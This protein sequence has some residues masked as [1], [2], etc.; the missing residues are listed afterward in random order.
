MEHNRQGLKDIL[1]AAFHDNLRCVALVN[2]FSE[3]VALHEWDLVT[4]CSK[5]TSKRFKLPRQLT[6]KFSLRSRSKWICFG[7]HPIKLERYRED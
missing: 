2:A 1:K 7:D 4:E 6:L 3:G 5:P